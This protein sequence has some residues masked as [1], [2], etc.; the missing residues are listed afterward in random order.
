MAEETLA[1]TTSATNPDHYKQP[2]KQQNQKS[3]DRRSMASME[4]IDVAEKFNLDMHLF[5]VIKY[6]LRA[7]KKGTGVEAEVEDLKK[8]R[9]YLNRK[10]NLL[11][12]R[13]SWGFHK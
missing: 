2:P 4:V 3:R 5:N 8:A 9:Q 10:I 6:T 11:E 1:V 12:G 7:G 13:H